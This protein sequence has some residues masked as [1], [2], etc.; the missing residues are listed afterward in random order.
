MG[1]EFIL[2]ALYFLFVLLFYDTLRKDKIKKRASI[3]AFLVIGGI[4]FY[5][6]KGIAPTGSMENDIIK[7]IDFALISSNL[8]FLLVKVIF[9]IL[10][11]ELPVSQPT[12]VLIVVIQTIGLLIAFKILG[13]ASLVIALFT[14]F[15]GYFFLI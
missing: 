5:F 3:I 13:I 15:V 4:N 9:G 2:A 8:N 7:R 6:T 12:F 14:V 10:E 11:K 1:F